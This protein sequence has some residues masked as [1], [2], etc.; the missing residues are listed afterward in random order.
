MNNS[1]SAQA[2]PSLVK[3]SAPYGQGINKSRSNSN[4]AKTVSEPKTKKKY[5][6]KQQV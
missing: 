5:Y 6:S 2:L 4:L 1:I 3:P